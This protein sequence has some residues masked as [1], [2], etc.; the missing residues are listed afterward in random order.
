M[1]LLLFV[2]DERGIVAGS[3]RR[4]LEEITV[5]NVFRC[6]SHRS[7]AAA[8]LETTVEHTPQ[9]SHRRVDPC[10][11]RRSCATHPSDPR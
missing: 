6:S 1:H 3:S 2:L 11:L 10:E 5:G 9:L 4:A 8:S 7:L